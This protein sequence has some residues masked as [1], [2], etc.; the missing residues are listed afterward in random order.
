MI[1]TI[2]LN[3]LVPS[4]RN[5]PRHS[6]AIADAELK[7]SIAARGLLPIITCALIVAFPGSLPIA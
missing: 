1:T 5:V 3:E 2:P 6:N 7:A 4:S